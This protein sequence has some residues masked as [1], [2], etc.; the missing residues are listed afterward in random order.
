MLGAT[1]THP[2]FDAADYET[3]LRQ[4]RIAQ[5]EHR[6]Q[7]PVPPALKDLLHRFRRSRAETRAQI[8]ALYELSRPVASCARDG[9]V[10][11]EWA[12]WLGAALWT[13]EFGSAANIGAEDPLITAM[14]TAA[15]RQ[16]AQTL[17]VHLAPATAAVPPITADHAYFALRLA[18]E[19]MTFRATR[20]GD[21]YTAV[22]VYPLP[23]RPRTVWPR[24]EEVGEA[25]WIQALSEPRETFALAVQ[26]ELDGWQVSPA[27]L[28]DGT[29]GLSL[30]R[31]ARQMVLSQDG[32]VG[33]VG[34]P[35]AGDVPALLAGMP[36]DGII[37]RLSWQANARCPVKPRE[38]EADG[39]LWCTP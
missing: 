14:L 21:R 7:Q 25:V 32:S 3:A 1:Q 20:Q 4:D 36:T 39:T 31:G 38:I 2:V 13:Q 8:H 10:N 12:V 23:P 15:P 27:H 33:I 37:H 29:R 26:L 16:G 11:F 35:R 5:I 6:L 19:S 18:G 22:P 34:R 28:S 17:E 30:C 9:P 24:W